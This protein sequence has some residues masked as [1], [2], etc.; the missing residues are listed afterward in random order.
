ML[1][2][3]ELGSQAKF[4]NVTKDRT[5]HLGSQAKFSNVTKDR[6]KQLGSQAKFSNVTKD[7][8][9]QLGPSALSFR[10]FLNTKTKTFPLT[11]KKVFAKVVNS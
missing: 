5:K 7:R 8:T 4:S 2:K 11:I 6:T 10:K 1:L 9:K 3:I